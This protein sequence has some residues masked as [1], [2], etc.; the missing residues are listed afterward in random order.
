MYIIYM[1]MCLLQ[2]EMASEE[3][4]GDFLVMCDIV[5]MHHILATV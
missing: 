1:G 2:G 5:M 3:P 4:P